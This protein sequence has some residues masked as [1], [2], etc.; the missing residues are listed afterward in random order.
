MEEKNEI[1]EGFFWGCLIGTIFILA[2][3]LVDCVSSKS[4]L[5]NR[6][7]FDVNAVVQSLKENGVA[8]SPDGWVMY[9]REGS[10]TNAYFLEEKWNAHSAI[11]FNNEQKGDDETSFEDKYLI[12]CRSVSYLGKGYTVCEQEIPAEWRE[13][14]SHR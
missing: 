13:P 11:Y 8:F 6:D 14:S 4:E 9:V 10:S 12:N 3:A 1:L 2:L 7:D 5:A